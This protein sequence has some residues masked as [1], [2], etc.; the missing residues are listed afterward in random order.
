MLLEN[1]CVYTYDSPGRKRKAKYRIARRNMD[2]RYLYSMES[3][4]EC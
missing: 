2:N 3:D 1:V 4:K